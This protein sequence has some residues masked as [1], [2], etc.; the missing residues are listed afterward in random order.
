MRRRGGGDV[1]SPFASPQVRA[2]LI[3]NRHEKLM[4]VCVERGW[5]DG[6]MS[7]MFCFVGPVGEIYLDWL[8]HFLLRSMKSYDNYQTKENQVET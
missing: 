3:L 8:E 7:L 5:G 6:I 4:G 2:A 1:P